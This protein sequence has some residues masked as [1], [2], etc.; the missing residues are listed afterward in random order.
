MRRFSLLLT[1]LALLSAGSTTALEIT[2]C[3]KEFKINTSSS[4]DQHH[5]TVAMN[6]KGIILV[7][8]CKKIS[9]E[10]WDI[11]CRPFQGSFGGPEFKINTFPSNDLYRQRVPDVATGR[12]DLF[13]AVWSG[14]TEA[15]L[16]KYSA[17]GRLFSADGSSTTL[18]IHDAVSSS[19]NWPDAAMFSDG[20]FVVICDHVVNGEILYFV[21]AFRADGSRAG[22]PVRIN[23]EPSYAP[24]RNIGFGLPDIA[25]AEVNGVKTGYAVWE[26]WELSVW[27]HRVTIVGRQFTVD[28]FIMGE[29]TAIIPSNNTTSRHRPMVDMNDEGEILVTWFERNYDTRKINVFARCRGASKDW[30]G[31]IEMPLPAGAVKQD[32]SVGRLFSNGSFVIAWNCDTTANWNRQDVMM[33]FFRSDSTPF[34]NEPITVTDDEFTRHRDQRRP[35]LDFIE[36]EGQIY[37]IVVWES[38]EQ[39]EKPLAWDTYGRFY[40]GTL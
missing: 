36:K 38:A 14:R 28:P 17:Y 26:R 32:R 8:W 13:V 7:P 33:Q 9:S 16:E 5:A 19:R 6:S 3:G 25:V 27:P 37:M 10:D 20:S 23:S 21:Q 4:G 39:L 35:A 11:R 40:M 1:V 15:G 34:G 31:T 12:D 22:P 30:N 29:E 24:N 2:P 18:R